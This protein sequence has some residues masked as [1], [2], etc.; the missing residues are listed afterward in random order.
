MNIIKSILTHSCPQCRSSKLFKEPFN[1]KNPLNIYE[2]CSVCNQ[3]FEPEPGF[4]FGALFIS[5]GLST[6][7]LLVPA[8]ILVLGFD[9]NP[10]NAMLLV[11]AIAAIS[12]F[13]LLR[14]SRSIWIHINVK[15][16]DNYTPQ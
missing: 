9:W 8:L 3:N 4:Y 5:Y 15:Y 14:V 16:D 6:F 7:L 1:F 12:Y 11:L 2:R 13:K 10:N